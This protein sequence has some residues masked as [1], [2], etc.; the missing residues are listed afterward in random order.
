ML[1]WGVCAYVCGVFELVSWLFIDYEHASCSS[2]TCYPASPV[3]RRTAGPDAATLLLTIRIRHLRSRVRF[4]CR[5]WWLVSKHP[6][7]FRVSVA[8][9]PPN[10]DVIEALSNRLAYMPS[11]HK[12]QATIDDE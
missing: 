1:V 11:Q 5:R 7:G 4:C 10:P 12:P 6:I 2:C 8:M 3:F 9:G